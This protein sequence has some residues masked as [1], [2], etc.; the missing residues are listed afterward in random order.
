SQ[1]LISASFTLI[2]EAIRLNFWPRVRIKYPTDLKGQIYIPSI[3][4]MLYAGCVGVVL[5][6]RESSHM[7]AAYGL[8]INIDMIMTSTL[9]VF[10]LSLRRYRSFIIFLFIAVY[11]TIEFSF[12]IANLD[13]FI[14]GGYV[15]M[16]ISLAMIYVMWA[17]YQA[18]KIRNRF[19]EFVKLKDYLPLLRDLSHDFSI[20][21]YATH[22]VYLTSANYTEEI[23]AKVVYS[24]LQKQP[25]RAD[26]YWF[27]HVDVMDEPYMME[28][29]VVELIKGNIVRVDFR[30][31]FRV[32]PRI[33]LMFRKVVEDMVK[34]FEVDITSRYESLGRKNLIG[35]FR[36]VVMEKF[37]SLEN[38]LPF[39]EKIILDTYFFFKRV[40][41][42][43]ERAFGLDTS[44]VTIEK[45]PMVVNPVGDIPLKRVK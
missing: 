36:F 20:P 31:G 37:L 27:V 25:K 22:L 15:S 39:Y 12:L 11:A 34:N 35:D 29:K 41:L 17:W 24:I 6:F 19:V 16:I 42:S 23:E 2:N 18:R 13:K 43:E 21:K 32:E 4:W 3:N 28:Y 40:S 45:V 8:T 33:N 5:F 26:I 10:Y 9:L 44:S 30:L 7:E 1:A 14:H 38:D